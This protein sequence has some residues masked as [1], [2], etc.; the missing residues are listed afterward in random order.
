MWLWNM[1]Y[2]F[3][4][5]SVWSKKK[6]VIAVLVKA[7]LMHCQLQKLEVNKAGLYIESI[8]TKSI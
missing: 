6:I 1:T 2:S 4:I 8:K 7:I 3:E 5:V